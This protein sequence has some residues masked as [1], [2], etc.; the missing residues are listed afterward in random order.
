MCFP[1][2]QID[3]TNDTTTNEGFDRFVGLLK[4]GSSA[5]REVSPDTKIIIHSA[6]ALRL[7]EGSPVNSKWFYQ[8]L[9]D[10]NL[11]Y[12]IIGSSLYSFYGDGPVSSLTN[13]IDTITT[14]FN[15]PFMVME[16]SYGFTTKYADDGTSNLLYTANKDVNY[17]LSIKGQAEEVHDILEQLNNA[18]NAIGYAYWGGEWIYSSSIAYN[19]WENQ[20]LFT[21]EGVALP[22]L[23]QFNN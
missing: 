1:F 16:N 17:D 20:A 21:F 9:A 6:N 22:V 14:E 2:G 15:K 13:V 8:K 7:Y 10:R 3:W 19:N 11:D 4:E 23:N 12:D 18:K 5:V